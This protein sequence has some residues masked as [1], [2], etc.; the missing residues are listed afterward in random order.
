MSLETAGA[1]GKESVQNN[2]NQHKK[3]NEST[4]ENEGKSLDLLDYSIKSLNAILYV[5]AQ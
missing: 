3:N 5:V 4:G 1:L 2:D